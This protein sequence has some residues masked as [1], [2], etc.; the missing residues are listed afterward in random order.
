MYY[1]FYIRLVDSPEAGEVESS[2]VD[3]LEE[4]DFDNSSNH[5]D[6]NDDDNDDDDDD[7]KDGDS[8]KND[9]NVTPELLVKLGKQLG[10]ETSSKER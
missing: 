9:D 2:F 4:K 10:Y 5:D 3:A 8:I 7:N 6:Y 1:E